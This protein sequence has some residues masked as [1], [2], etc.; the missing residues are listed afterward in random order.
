LFDYYAQ[1]IRQM[2][3]RVGRV[4]FSIFSEKT[5]QPVL[6]APLKQEQSCTVVRHNVGTD[7]N[8][9]VDF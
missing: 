5:E 1:A 8:P 7:G 2:L 4:P 3:L 6:L 9:E